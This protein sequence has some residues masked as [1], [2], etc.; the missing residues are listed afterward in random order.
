MQQLI[1]DFFLP[2]LSPSGEAAAHDGALLDLAQARLAFTTDSYVV[3]PPFFPGGDIG[4]LAVYGTVND[5]AMCGARPIC[6]SAGFILEEGFPIRDLARILDTMKRALASCGISVVTGDT[7]VVDRGKGDG[8]YI[9]T[10]GIGL[11]EHGQVWN[12]RQVR[13]GDRILVSGDIGRH[14]MAVLSVRTGLMFETDLES[15]VSALWGP[16]SSLLSAGIQA[17][18]LRDLTRGGLSSALNEIAQASGLSL[19]IREPAVPVSEEVRSACEILGYDPFYVA[20]EGRFV[21]F[22]PPEEAD[23]ALS[24]L[25][26]NPGTSGA[27]WI[28]EVCEENAGHPSPR[29]ILRNTIGVERILDMLSGE[30]LPRIC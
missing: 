19:R 17:H 14:G 18:C 13:P 6:L 27:A 23:R 12:P 7:K 8:I 21:A 25:R 4:S 24:V 20:C 2:C 5:L 16:V 29:V 1:R 28:G 9:N 15:D 11:R 30:Q 26:A 10:S 3:R 22:L